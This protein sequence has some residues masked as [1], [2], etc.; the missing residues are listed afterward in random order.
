MIFDVCND[1]RINELFKIADG[2]ASS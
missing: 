2:N 1:D